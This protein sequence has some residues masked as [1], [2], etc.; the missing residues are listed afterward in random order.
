M[1][2]VSANTRKTRFPA[3]DRG[4]YDFSYTSSAGESTE[5]VLLVFLA[6]G[7]PFLAEFIYQVE[8][9]RKHDA[10]K[11]GGCERKI[12]GSVLPPVKYVTGQAANR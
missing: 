5:P 1:K 11:E 10:E 3:G 6:T 7:D 4:E 9:Q 12:E 8:C 2:A